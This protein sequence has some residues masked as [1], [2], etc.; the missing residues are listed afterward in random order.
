VK[1]GGSDNKV[2]RGE[3]D[4]VDVEEISNMFKGLDLT[5]YKV[6]NYADFDFSG[7][8]AVLNFMGDSE[9]KMTIEK[10]FETLYISLKRMKANIE[11][12]EKAYSLNA[13]IEAF[14][15]KEDDIELEE[16]IG[17]SVDLYSNGEFSTNAV[18]MKDD[19]TS[20]FTFK[21]FT[22]EWKLEF[23]NCEDDS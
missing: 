8:F 2:Y 4:A 20:L 12:V 21:K 6:K 1:S 11:M 17:F 3:G 16:A 7:K 22:D 9:N 14:K 13:T 10:V 5:N 15:Y 23:N 19:N 18:I